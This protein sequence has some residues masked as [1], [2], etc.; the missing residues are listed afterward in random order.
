MPLNP[1]T[2][3]E[4]LVDAL[5][6][7]GVPYALCGGLALGVHGHPRATEDIDLLIE[8]ESLERAL[9]AA[10]RLGF[11]VPARK[12]VFGLRYGKRREVQRVSKLDPDTGDLMPLDFLLV[13]DELGEVWDTR[14]TVDVGVRKLSVVSRWGL[15]TMKRM[16]GR[17]RDLA[18]LEMLE[19]TADDEE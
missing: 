18:D 13:N 11:D 2:E 5:D 1:V 6:A 15:A 3:L 14:Q 12:M 17:T 16:A 9:A 4:A 10:K 19:G 7:D 8:T